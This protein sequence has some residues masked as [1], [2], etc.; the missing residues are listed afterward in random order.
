MIQTGEMNSQ[1]AGSGRGARI[2]RR[3][4]ARNVLSALRDGERTMSF[5]IIGSGLSS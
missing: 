3:I 4:S 2:V 5:A 1:D